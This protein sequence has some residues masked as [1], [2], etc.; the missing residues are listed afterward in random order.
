LLGF[1]GED[2]QMIEEIILAHLER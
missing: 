2:V 1:T